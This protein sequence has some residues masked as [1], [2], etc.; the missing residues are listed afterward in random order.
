LA[1]RIRDGHWGITYGWDE[2]FLSE[3]DYLASHWQWI[4]PVM[5]GEWIDW[6]FRVRWSYG[7]D[8]LTEVWRNGEIVM[9]RKGPNTYNDFRGVYL[10]LGLYHPVRHETVY[11]DRI[12]ISDAE[13]PIQEADVRAGR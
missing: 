4:G 1:L 5:R 12:S 13:G 6:T 8:G 10:K 2:K 9:Q 11:L 7:E 3:A